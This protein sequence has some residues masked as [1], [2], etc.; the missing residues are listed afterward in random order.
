MYLNLIFLWLDLWI[1]ITHNSEIE[2]QK[3][4]E[5]I[6]PI[7]DRNNQLWVLIISIIDI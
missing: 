6:S 7:Y 1:Y 4:T 5:Y 2:L 3:Y